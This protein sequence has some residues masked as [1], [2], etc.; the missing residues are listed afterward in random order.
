MPLERG[1]GDFRLPALH[2]NGT[3]PA[4]SPAFRDEGRSPFRREAEA[5]SRNSSCRYDS[6]GT[7]IVPIRSDSFVRFVSIFYA[8]NI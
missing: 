2:Q 3:G 7:T 1:R 5:Y 4:R 6:V 8:K